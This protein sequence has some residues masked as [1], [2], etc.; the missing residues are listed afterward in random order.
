MTT[1]DK[2]P[3]RKLSTLQLAQELNNVSRACAIRGYSRQQFYEIRRYVQTYG[4]EGLIDRLPG[5]RGPHPNRSRQI[6]DR[7]AI[8]RVPNK[9]LAALR[10]TGA[11]DEDAVDHHQ[12]RLLQACRS[13]AGT[14]GRIT[15]L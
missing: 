3:R 15:S 8:V 1:K 14:V 4:A 13:R 7:I 12:A 10:F 5:P 11:R 6:D 9:T 2:L